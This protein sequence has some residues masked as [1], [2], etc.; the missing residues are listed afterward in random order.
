MIQDKDTLVVLLP[1]GTYTTFAPL[2]YYSYNVSVQSGYDVLAIEYGFQRIDK[3]VEFNNDTY[4]LLIKE[5]KEAV[6]KALDKKEYKHL[7][8]IGK[9]LGTYIQNVI[10]KEFEKYNQKHIFLTPWAE[11]V[12]GI[13]KTDS[14]VIVGTN[15]EGFKQEHIDMISNNKNVNLKIIEGANHDLEKDDYVDSL[16]LLLNISNYIYKFINK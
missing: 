8:F 7:I 5:V 2:L 15:D 1:G 13:N 10:R 3:K 16:E 6:R 4:L 9:C 12:E 11:C 14:M